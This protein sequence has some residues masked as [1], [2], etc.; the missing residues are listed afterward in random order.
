MIPFKFRSFFHN[1]K[2]INI[3]KETVFKINSKNKEIVTENNSRS[4][5]KIFLCAGPY[6]SQKI[7]S[8]GN[9]NILRIIE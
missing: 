7:I 5:E 2:N 9:L 8:F 1:E 3:I 6:Q 4:Y